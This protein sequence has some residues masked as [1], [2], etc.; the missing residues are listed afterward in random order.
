M[1]NFTVIAAITKKKILGYQ[2]FK[3]SP[4][5]QGIGAFMISLLEN[6]PQI[7]ENPSQYVFFMDNASIHT[8]YILKPFFE[9][10]RVL[11]NAPYS[12]FLNPIEEFFGNWKF[13]FRK[14]FSQNTT[15]IR[16]RIH[17]SLL[18]IDTTN[19]FSFFMHSVTF[20]KDCLEMKP[21]L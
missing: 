21:I 8:A 6:N 2:I 16:V 4:K 10:L 11:F 12:P 5:A 20:L 1:V 7:L 19:L 14:R 9:N 17:Q 15:N 3:G 13:Y 18:D